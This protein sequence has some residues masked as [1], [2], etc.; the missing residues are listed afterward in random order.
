VDLSASFISYSVS[1]YYNKLYETE[2]QE[3][4]ELFNERLGPLKNRIYE[5]EE[6]ELGFAGIYQRKIFVSLLVKYFVVIVLSYLTACLLVK[7]RK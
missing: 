4:I 6:G 1:S 3:L 2:A 5:V 7:V